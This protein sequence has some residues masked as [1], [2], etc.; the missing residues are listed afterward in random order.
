MCVEADARL[1]HPL[2]PDSFYGQVRD[3]PSQLSNHTGGMQIS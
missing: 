2:S 3:T 1:T